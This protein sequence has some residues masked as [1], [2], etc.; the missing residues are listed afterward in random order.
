MKLSLLAPQ[1][2]GCWGWLLPLLMLLG[3]GR[4]WGQ[5][6]TLFSENG[7]EFGNSSMNYANGSTN[8]WIRYN[9]SGINTT[10]NGSYAFYINNNANI[11][12]NAPSYNKNT[13]QV[14]HIYT[15]AFTIPAGSASLDINF[16]WAAVGEVTGGVDYDYLKV[17]LVSGSTTPTAGN[18]ITSFVASSADL[19]SQNAFQTAKL[20]AAVTAGLSYRVVF[21]WTNDD[22][23]GSNPG[24]IIDDIVINTTPAKP[25]VSLAAVAA[26]CANSSFNLV[27][28]NTGTQTVSGAATVNGAIPDN[29][30]TGLT[31]TIT[32][33]G[34]STAKITASSVVRVFLNID[35][36][37]D[38]DLQVYL[39]DPSGTKALE[40]TTGNGGSGTDY[41]NTILLTSATNVIGTSGNNTSPFSNTYRPEGTVSTGPSFIYGGIPTSPLVGATIAGGWKLR[42]FDNGPNDVGYLNNWSL[43]ITDVSLYPTTAITPT[44][45]LG[46]LGTTTYSGTTN[47]TATTAVSNAPAGSDTYTA[48]TTDPSGT[49]A[50]TATTVTVKPS[51]TATLTNNGP[52]CAGSTA[53]VSVALTGTSPWTF[54]YSDGSA[55]TTVTSTTTN[56]YVITTP[57]LA[58]SKT[59]SL[60]ALTGGGCSA[61]V[62]ALAAATTTII[63]NPLPTFTTTQTNV[64]CIGSNTG[65]ITVSA[66]GGVSGGTYQY[67]K[68]N[69]GAYQSSNVFGGLVAGTYQ[70][71]VRNVGGTQCAAAAQSV[72]ITQPATIAASAS[73]TNTCAGSSSGSITVS[74]SG[75]TGTF[76]YSK[77]GTTFQTSNTFTNVA[78]GAYTLTVKDANGCTATTTATVGNNPLPTT[79]LTSATS[80]TVCAGTSATLTGTLNGTA[81]FSGTYTVNGGP[82][83]SF[84]TPN[85]ALTINTPNLPA[86]SYTVTFT[87]LSDANSCAAVTANLPSVT[88]T[89]T[90][91]TTW[92]GSTSSDWYDAANWT[93]C[94]PTASISAVI[95]AS[96]PNAPVITSGSARANN[97]TLQ[98]ALTLTLANAGTSLTLAGSLS[99]ATA[100]TFVGGSGTSVTFNATTV[101]QTIAGP[102]GATFDDLSLTGLP[103]ALGGP[104]TI[105]NNLK[106]SAAMLLLGS[107]DLTM[108]PGTGTITNAGP[109]H[110][111]ALNGTGRLCFQQVGSADRPTAAYLVGVAADSYTPASLFNAGTPDDFYLSLKTG[112]DNPV[113]SGQHYVNRQW[114]IA[115]AI[116]GGSNATLTLQWNEAEENPG[117]DR[118]LCGVAHYTGGQWDLSCASCIAAAQSGNVPNSYKRTRSGLTS[119]SPF[120]VED[121]TYPLPVELTSFAA[122][123]QGPQARLDWTTATER[124]SQGFEV[125]VSTDGQRF[126]ALGFVPGAG[127]SF[128]AHTYSFLDREPG[129]AGT[130]YYRLRQ[131]DFDGTASLTQVRAVDFGGAPAAASLAAVPN[132]FGSEL[133][134]LVNASQPVA[135][136]Q[137]TL[138][139]ML[140]RVVRRQPVDLPAGD[141]QLD[142]R[143]TVQ[144]LPTGVYLLQLPL[145]G[146]L[147]TLKITKE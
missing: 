25:T 80:T 24:G 133:R 94:V 71:V 68:N 99:T 72:T 51:P 120:A 132:P 42:V 119:F 36:Q 74:A 84:S 55:S 70:V 115:E 21:T 144:G 50:T 73:A 40:L 89:A 139:D 41:L 33:G 111:V 57:A 15:P 88:I 38:S 46:T 3:A 106:L 143:E 8:T 103:K 5:T 112:V 142:L 124:N 9:Y 130:R 12:S 26:Q 113:V 116:P 34:V 78:A 107:F 100:N 58:A 128:S 104:V 96:A 29:S 67:S 121:N 10:P 85:N 122:T 39:V 66:A 22:N 146:Q 91:T 129:K 52:V 54:T 114:D 6:T 87:S 69:G 64:S 18:Q 79:T 93:Y 131:V 7:E 49:T 60:T 19:L 43:S 13:A 44:T 77:D 105:T 95:P 145:D 59:Y 86:G 61:T 101:A 138:T 45:G 140:G 117:F 126:R 53:T 98:G 83:V 35:H 118:N 28:T 11:F 135:G 125:Q 136:Q 32:L 2:N 108:A 14:S 110:F 31:S 23:S 62:A 20:T 109:G 134:V 16:N 97:V 30:T 102:G 75:G 56:P 63:V 27:A 127:T 76:T 147:R 65:S 141:S 81:P 47:T 48:T 82:A 17:Y 37:Y 137:L 90:T 4:A 92:T 123:R 1:R